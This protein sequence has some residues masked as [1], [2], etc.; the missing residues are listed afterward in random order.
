MNVMPRDTMEHS[1][2]AHKGTCR[3]LSAHHHIFRLYQLPHSWLPAHLSTSHSAP[4]ASDSLRAL[5][6]SQNRRPSSRLHVCTSAPRLLAITNPSP[7]ESPSL[8]DP[9]RNSGLKRTLNRGNTETPSCLLQIPH[10]QPTSISTLSQGPCVARRWLRSSRRVLPETRRDSDC[11]G[12]FAL[13]LSN[14]GPVT[15]DFWEKSQKRTK[16]VRPII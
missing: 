7:V 12:G 3:H 10:T 15:V 8:S 2:R 11:A 13:H 9:T 16:I 4:V 1:S 5:G 14:Q 6:V